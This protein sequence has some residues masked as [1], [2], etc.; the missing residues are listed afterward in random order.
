[1]G[2]SPEPY[3]YLLRSE[4]EPLAVT[5]RPPVRYTLA[6]AFTVSR[7]TTRARRPALVAPDAARLL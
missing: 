5:G 3:P 2:A 6:A 7:H 4:T 1:M